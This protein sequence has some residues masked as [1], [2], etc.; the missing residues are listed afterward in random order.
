M[1]CANQTISANETSLILAFSNLVNVGGPVT[2]KPFSFIIS[3]GVCGESL[4]IVSLSAMILHSL[5]TVS[6]THL[7]LPTNREV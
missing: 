1:F 5:S 7:T 4:V 6:Y 3:V 2:T